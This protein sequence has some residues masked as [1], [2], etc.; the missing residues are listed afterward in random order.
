MVMIKLVPKVMKNQTAALI[1]IKSNNTKIKR[2]LENTDSDFEKEADDLIS[3]FDDLEL[4]EMLS[5]FMKSI[6]KSGKWYGLF[7]II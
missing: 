2:K 5:E 6:K 1:Q 4:N 3:E 7:N